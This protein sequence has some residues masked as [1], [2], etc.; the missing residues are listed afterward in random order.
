MARTL[1]AI[2]LLWADAGYAY[3]K[4]PLHC[5]PINSNEHDEDRCQK[6]HEVP[7]SNLAWRATRS[8]SPR[9]PVSLL[10]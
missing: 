1:I 5:L 6:E 7:A 10:P 4:H 9:P 3:Q 8:S 2:E